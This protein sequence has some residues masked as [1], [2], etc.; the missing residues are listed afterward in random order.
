LELREFAMDLGCYYQFGMVDILAVY[1]GLA[2]KKKKR[3]LEWGALL[4]TA[5]A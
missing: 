3:A 1:R 5:F 4:K 2:Q